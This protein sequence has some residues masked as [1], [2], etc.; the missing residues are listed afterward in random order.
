MAGDIFLELN[1]TPIR[2]R[3]QATEIISTNQN[4]TLPLTVLRGQDSVN[5]SVT[6]GTDGT[7][8]VFIMQNYSGPVE[9]KTQGFFESFYL[10]WLE[11]NRMTQLTFRM[12]G[13]VISG[14][15]EFGKAF[16]GP[17]KIAQFA[18]KSAD[19]GVLSFLYFLALLSL[20]LAI[21]NIMPFPVLDGGHLVIIF[22]E[23]IFKREIPIKVKVAIQNV[24]FVLLL[25]LMAFILYN[26]ILN[27]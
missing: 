21:I 26:D 9:L 2:L 6:P 3:Q 11:I 19:S 22:I 5:L 23:S 17:I 12:I 10:G 27:I 4:K 24:G 13:K 25:L 20:S 14:N 18:A 16:G 7:I 8:G 15:I 1:K